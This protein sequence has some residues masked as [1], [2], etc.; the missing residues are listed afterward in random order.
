MLFLII[1][2]FV[3]RLANL[4]SQQ[5]GVV[6]S[7]EGYFPKPPY[8]NSHK[9]FTKIEKKFIFKKNLFPLLIN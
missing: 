6:G 4:L 2:L 9:I 1:Q 5:E 8:Y 7:K 3:G